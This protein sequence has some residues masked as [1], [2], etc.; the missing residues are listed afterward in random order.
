MFARR[1]S[2][3]CKA[4]TSSSRDLNLTQLVI[5]VSFSVAKF[6][7]MHLVLFGSVQR[8]L[9][10]WNRN[11]FRYSYKKPNSCTRLSWKPHVGVERVNK[12]G[13]TPCFVVIIKP[14]ICWLFMIKN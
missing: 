9:R 2:R 7:T 6:I 11:A 1:L 10:A 13:K 12:K 5:P 8:K 14:Y 4:N 3:M